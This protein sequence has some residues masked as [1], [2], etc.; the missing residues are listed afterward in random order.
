MKSMNIAFF[1]NQIPDSPLEHIRVVGPISYTNINLLM[2]PELKNNIYKNIYEADLVL[3]QRVFPSDFNTFKKILNISR[4]LEKPLVFDLDDNLFILPENHPDRLAFG[5][6]R[7]LMPMLYAAFNSDLVTVS[8]EYLKNSLSDLN[9]NIKVLPN[10]IDDSIW[11]FAP[12]KSQ[13]IGEAIKVGYM[14]GDSHKPDLEMISKILID[15]KDRYAD[16]IGYHFY[17]IKPPD[18]ILALPDTIWTPIKTYNYADFADEF[19]NLDV[20][21]FLAPLV[22]NE[23]NRCKSSIK[24]MEYSVLGVPGIYSQVVPYNDIV[25]NGK[26]G[27][28]ATSVEEWKKYIELLVNNPTLRHQIGKNAQNLVKENYLMSQNASKWHRVYREV[29]DQGISKQSSNSVP[30]AMAETITHQLHDYQQ[31]IDKKLSQCYT[32]LNAVKYELKARELDIEDLKE[33]ILDYALSKS[34]RLTR[35]L[36]KFN[37]IVKGR[38][39]H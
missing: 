39:D 3:I 7:A 10:Y 28:L 19:Q 26:S 34:W 37:K 15:V 30:Q 1:T 32:K 22:D 12:P 13:Q 27:F 21:F 6:S 5:V 14:G 11:T 25:E 8:N 35:P 33:E 20:D 31:N 17:G 2:G 24:F 9:G 38:N 16:K 36:R 18:A 29:I 23:F 4:T